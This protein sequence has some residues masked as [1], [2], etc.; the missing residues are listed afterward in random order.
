[1]TMTNHDLDLH[2]E[3]PPLPLPTEE[4]LVGLAMSSGPLAAPAS[5][6]IPIAVYLRHEVGLLPDWYMP[7][8][9]SR[10]HPRWQVPVV[11]TL[12]ATFLLIEGFG[13]CSTFG[14]VVPA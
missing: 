12:V 5:D 2:D 4:E 1:M 3:M 8:P 11:L 6:A 13:L 9:M 14:Q 7:A 10:V